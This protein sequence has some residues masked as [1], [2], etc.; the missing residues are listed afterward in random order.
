VEGVTPLEHQDGEQKDGSKIWQG[1]QA[2]RDA[3][4]RQD[5]PHHDGANGYR[6][7]KPEEKIEKE[8]SEVTLE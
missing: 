5:H 6:Q 8:I 4:R 7:H 2:A 3:A 1:E